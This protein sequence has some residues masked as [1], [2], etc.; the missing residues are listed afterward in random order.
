MN[1][2][3]QQS[4]NDTNVLV[5]NPNSVPDESD[6][7]H[8][9]SRFG[10][11]NISKNEILEIWCQYKLEDEV[12]KEE[13][14]IEHGMV[15]KL[16]I[17]DDVDP[18]SAKIN[19]T[20]P[21]L[22]KKGLGEFHQVRVTTFGDDSTKQLVCDCQKFNI[23][24]SCNHSKRFGL[25]LLQ[26][27]PDYKERMFVSP[28][29][30]NFEQI[31]GREIT[32]FLGA[33]ETEAKVPAGINLAHDKFRIKAPAINP[34]HECSSNLGAYETEAKVPAGI[35]L[36]HD[37]FKIKAPPI[38]PQYESSSNLG[39]YKTEAN[40]P[41]VINLDHDK[42]KIKAPTINPQYESSS[43]DAVEK[44]RTVDWDNSKSS[45]KKR[46]SG[47]DVMHRV[48]I[49]ESISEVQMTTQEAGNRIAN[50]GQVL[51]HSHQI[52]SYPFVQ[53]IHHNQVQAQQ[54]H[55]LN[56]LS[57]HNQFQFQA[58]QD[59]QNVH[60]IHQYS[61]RLPRQNQCVDDEQYSSYGQFQY[62][63]PYITP[64]FGG[65]QHHQ[66]SRPHQN[67]YGYRLPTIDHLQDTPEHVQ[68][69]E[70]P[71]PN[72]SSDTSGNNQLM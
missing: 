23:D 10:S 64:S 66:M 18:K 7:C 19:E 49:E 2:F 53:T 33:Y 25:L 68:Q 21:L 60:P 37:K 34:Q 70:P 31:R 28:S 41:A 38:N 48:G 1:R 24:A 3:S 15:T 12:I 8:F 52:Y 36:D 11:K 16:G 61:A 57:N 32:M 65:R 17:Y 47:E 71:F 43:N 39:A 9:A 35:N 67:S 5:Y 72:I 54:P 42:F 44:K 22:C 56:L 69:E 40:V 63:I 26:Q 62:N 45:N 58:P 50:H 4:F 20:W 59:Y 14:E 46:P 27:Y 55:L 6:Y 29:A 30:S 13:L 51:D